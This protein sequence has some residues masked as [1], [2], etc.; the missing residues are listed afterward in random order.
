ME[1]LASLG[2]K[3]LSHAFA[4]KQDECII[5]PLILVIPQSSVNAISARFLPYIVQRLVVG[6]RLFAAGFYNLQQVVLQRY[7]SREQTLC[8]YDVHQARRVGNLKAVK[9]CRG[10]PVLMERLDGRQA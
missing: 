6:L 1:V 2:S 10:V 7:I 9:K 5:T 3:L 8:S 4:V